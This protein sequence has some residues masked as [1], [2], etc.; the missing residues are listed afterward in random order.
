[1]KGF[2]KDDRASNIESAIRQIVKAVDRKDIASVTALVQRWTRVLGSETMV[3]LMTNQ[4]LEQIEEPLWFLRQ[5]CPKEDFVEQSY[6]AI[7]QILVQKGMVP[8]KDF[9]IHKNKGL[10]LSD[11]AK[12]VMI[13][14]TPVE[15]RHKI[16]KEFEKESNKVSL[17]DQSFIKAMHD[18]LG[19]DFYF[20]LP[21]IARERVNSMENN[22]AIAA[23]CV[24]LVSGLATRNPEINNHNYPSWLIGYMLQDLHSNRRELVLAIASNNESKLDSPWHFDDIFKALGREIH[25]IEVDSKM[26]SFLSKDDMK[27]LDLV[28]VGEKRVSDFV[29]AFDAWERKQKDK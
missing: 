7:A 10:W 11:A 22:H 13:Q 27:V 14:S 16:I 1:M 29:A 15:H 28:W 6:L 24:Y 20:R 12:E 4:V 23:Y 2:G 19:I 9:S 17:N 8:G 21:D 25:Q 18:R 26:E 5:V 3:D